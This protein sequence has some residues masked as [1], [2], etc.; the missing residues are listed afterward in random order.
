MHF[1]CGNLTYDAFLTLKWFDI[2]E[3]LDLRL[4]INMFKITFFR[5][6]FGFLLAYNDFEKKKNMTQ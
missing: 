3:I 1:K 2:L 5:V 4:V 6:S